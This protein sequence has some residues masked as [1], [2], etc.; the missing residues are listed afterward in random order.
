M[1]ILFFYLRYCIAC[2]GDRPGEGFAGEFFSKI[3]EI[4]G[5][6]PVLVI[7]TKF[8]RLIGVH[9]AVLG[10]QHQDWSYSQT[11]KYAEGEALK[12][13]DA[14]YLKQ[15]TAKLKNGTKKVG[16]ERV[17]RVQSPERGGVDS[18]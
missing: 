3:D 8:D 18:G 7:F 2:E 15:V 1:L 4:A 17:G 12:D 9:H 10:R 14:K 13:F 5:E 11:I 16:W 6:T